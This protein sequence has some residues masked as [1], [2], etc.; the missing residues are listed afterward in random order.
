MRTNQFL[1]EEETFSVPLDIFDIINVCKQFS[2]LG[3][4]VQAQIECI[5]ELGIE[6]AVRNQMVSVASLPLIKNFLKEI[7]NNP[8]FGDATDQAFDCFHLIEMFE[9]KHPELYLNVNLN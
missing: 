8:Y 2:Q 5:M 1:E 9:D 3:F 6:E 7:V 4:K